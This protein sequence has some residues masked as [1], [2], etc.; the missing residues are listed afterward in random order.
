MME[1]ES[2]LHA[3][4]PPAQLRKADLGTQELHQSN[5]IRQ[6]SNPTKFSAFSVLSV[7]KKRF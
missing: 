4:E 5:P 6:S 3:G 2:R 1:E 7:D